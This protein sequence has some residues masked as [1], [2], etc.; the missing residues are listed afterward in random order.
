M[1]V[2]SKNVLSVLLADDDMDDRMLFEDAVSEL[3]M[4]IHVQTVKD[5]EEL[6]KYLSTTIVLPEIIFLDLNMPIKDGF[7]CLEEIRKNKLL[8]NIITIIYSTS[9]DPKDI[10]TAFNK[11]AN[12][13]ISKP[14]SF[15][16]LKNM[17]YKV[18]SFDLKEYMKPLQRERFVFK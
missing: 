4:N 16:Q 14:N 8:Q 1:E 17:L 10:D 15:T 3:A 2:P 9:V 12:L 18:F 11:G 5:G 6:M 7:K 13:F